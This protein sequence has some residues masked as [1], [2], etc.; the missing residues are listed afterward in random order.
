MA[1][2]HSQLCGNGCVGP[3][4]DEVTAFFINTYNMLTIDA[5]VHTGSGTKSV[6]EIPKFWSNFAYAIGSHVL[7]LD[8]IEHG[9]L[10]GLWELRGGYL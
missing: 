6:L 2:S 4:P 3:L 1:R 9:I 5:I 10:R 7:T 8:D